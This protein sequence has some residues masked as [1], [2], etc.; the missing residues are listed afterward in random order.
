[1]DI[2]IQ[3]AFAAYIFSMGDPS[4]SWTTSLA[5]LVTCSWGIEPFTLAESAL[6]SNAE[7]LT[8]AVCV[9][10]VTINIEVHGVKMLSHKR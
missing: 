4:G 8:L 5:V 1:M 10:K 9:F 7:H 6:S 3:S 2:F